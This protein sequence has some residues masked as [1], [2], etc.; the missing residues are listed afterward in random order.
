MKKC[1]LKIAAMCAVML[2]SS[3]MASG[4]DVDVDF[5]GLFGISPTKP[6]K[7]FDTSNITPGVNI[8]TGSSGAFT[9]DDADAADYFYNADKRTA[10]QFK[11]GLAE[12]EDMGFL[13]LIIYTYSVF[14]W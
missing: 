2:S 10:Y 12:N 7:Q 3:I 14:L 11:Y 4:T 13:P 8:L 6:Q 1:F 9:F 5:D